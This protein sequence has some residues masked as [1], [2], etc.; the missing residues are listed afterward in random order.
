[1][2]RLVNGPYHGQ[3]S[4][5]ARVFELRVVKAAQR[6]SDWDKLCVVRLSV[7]HGNEEGQRQVIHL[8]REDLVWLESICDVRDIVIDDRVA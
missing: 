4:L 3:R 5:L 7:V 6:L 1:M 8:F 2:I